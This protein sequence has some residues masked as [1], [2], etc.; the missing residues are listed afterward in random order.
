MSRS[1]QRT[2]APAMRPGSLAAPW[3]IAAPRR[4]LPRVSG[5]AMRFRTLSA[6]PT[7]WTGWRRWVG[8]LA[9]IGAIVFLGA[10][11]TATDAEFAFASIALLPVL[12]IAW[13]ESRG[14]AVFVAF[15]AAAVWT[16]GD[17]AS[18]RQFSA[19]WIPW[20][21]AVTRLMTYGFV[22]I[23]ASQVRLQF[24]REHEYA[25]R[26]ALTGLQNRRVFLEAGGY[27]VERSKRYKLPL[28]VIFL[29]LDDFK[30][31]NDSRGH[32]VGDSA[33]KAVSR[34][35]LDTLRSSDRVARLG[36]DEFAALLPEIGY[37][38][39]VDAGRKLSVAVNHALRGF[40]PAQVS[41]G[42][43]W[44]ADIDR[45]FLQMLQAADDLMYEVKQSG[46]GEMRSRSIAA[47]NKPETASG[48]AARGRA[49]RPTT[50]GHPSG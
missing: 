25:T 49:A 21:N 26:D 8:W 19:V 33:L 5:L 48:D 35:L 37:E 17:I 43:A 22:A 15:V 50:R 14:K 38:A 18:E 47:V 9:C 42:V 39:A 41:V 34:A 7:Q 28:T 46:K 31:L 32:G 36:G 16:V 12:V 1:Q 6:F 30:Q 40:Q 20:A 23:L 24:A 11:R 2:G 4:I 10:V 3:W 45:S 29:D 44:F 13:M 27:E